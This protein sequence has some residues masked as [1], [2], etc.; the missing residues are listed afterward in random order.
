MTIFASNRPSA[1]TGRHGAR[2]KYEDD[3]ASLFWTR[4][5][6][7]LYRAGKRGTGDDRRSSGDAP[8]RPAT[9]ASCSASPKARKSFWKNAPATGVARRGGD[10]SAISRRMQ[11]CWGLHPRP[12]R[13]TRCRR[14]LSTLRP[15]MS[16]RRRGNGPGPTSA[17]TGVLGPALGRADR[18]RAQGGPTHDW[19]RT[20]YDWLIPF[21]SRR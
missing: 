16:H 17:S 11:S 2:Q 5:L 14:R 12:C 9:P 18:F 15:R 6:H 1:R 8:E 20:L 13:A 3:C 21:S 4:P 19:L 10:V 7:R